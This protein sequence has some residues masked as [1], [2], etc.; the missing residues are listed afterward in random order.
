MTETMIEIDEAKA[1]R[2]ACRTCGDKLMPWEVSES[3]LCIIC[4]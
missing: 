1:T 3:M 2:L 4:E